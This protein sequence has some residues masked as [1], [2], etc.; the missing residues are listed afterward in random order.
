M[1]GAEFIKNSPRYC[2]WLVDIAPDELRSMPKV[3]ERVSNVR[4]VRLKS[5]K[6]AT[7]KSALS[8]HVFQEI[9]QPEDDYL[10]IPEISGESRKYIPIGFNPSEIIAS[11]KLQVI[12]NATYY[13]FGILTSNV[14]MAWMRVVAGRMGNSYQYSNKRVYSNFPWPNITKKQKENIK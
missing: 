12:P 7:Q 1:G 11:N 3:L 13:E 8:P 2:L 5:P 4:D 6:V 10:I 14:H 9:R